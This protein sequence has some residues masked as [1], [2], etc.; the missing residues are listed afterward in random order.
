M[1]VKVN[2]RNND[3]TKHSKPSNLK[4]SIFKAQDQSGTLLGRDERVILSLELMIIFCYVIDNTHR[5]N[6]CKRIEVSEARPRLLWRRK[7]VLYHRAEG[8]R[9][10]WSKTASSHHKRFRTYVEV[11]GQFMTI[12]SNDCARSYLLG[13]HGSALL[14]LV[15]FCAVR[16]W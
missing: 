9:G 16:R 3:I 7:P 15:R 12:I 4:K 6:R 11:I 14:E 1:G 2:I 8:S 10:E 13:N 5:V